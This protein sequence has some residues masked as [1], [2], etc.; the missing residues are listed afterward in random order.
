MSATKSLAQADLRDDCLDVRYDAEQSAMV[1][2]PEFVTW[3]QEA[4]YPVESLEMEESVSV[5]PGED[6]SGNLL[7]VVETLSRP[8]D[9]ADAV[10]DSFT[11]LGC[12]CPGFGYHRF[13]ALDDGEPITAVGE[14]SHVEAWRKRRRDERDDGQQPLLK[15]VPQP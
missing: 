10:A 4:G 15:E 13:P 3:M 11:F 6:N 14:C 7:F 2:Q 12:S 9:E 1:V 8:V 5:K